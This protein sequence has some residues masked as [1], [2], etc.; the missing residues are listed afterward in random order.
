MPCDFLPRPE[1]ASYLYF[2]SF[3]LSVL[4]HNVWK[5]EVFV[6]SRQSSIEHACTIII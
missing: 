5:A 3:A 6:S 2:T 1:Q 4:E